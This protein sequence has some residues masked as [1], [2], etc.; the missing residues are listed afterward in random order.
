M[1]QSAFA[2]CEEVRAPPAG[3]DRRSPVFCPKPRRL[4]PLSPVDP[5]RPLRWHVSHQA[6]LSEP[7]AGA[8]LL[9]L[10]LTKGGRSEQRGIISAVL[11]RVRPPTRC[12][13]TAGPDGPFG[14]TAACRAGPYPVRRR[15][16]PEKAA[17]RAKSA[18]LPPPSA[19]RASTSGRRSCGGITPRSR[20][21]N[22]KIL[23]FE[24]QKTKHNGPQ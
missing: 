2:T 13:R 14:E 7:K 21:I 9:D 11:I 4:G 23:L 6:D 15:R 12:H 8:E 18:R 10:F 17:S 16:P 1:Q 19:S 22:N 20:I 3:P 24:T 5:V